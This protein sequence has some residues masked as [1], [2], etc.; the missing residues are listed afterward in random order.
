MKKKHSREYKLLTMCLFCEAAA[1]LLAMLFR[2]VVLN[3]FYWNPDRDYDFYKM[4]FVVVLSFYAVV[5]RLRIKKHPSFREM[6]GWE[7]LAE[8]LKQHIL[9]LIGLTVFL[10]FIHS[11]DKISRT[12]M[13]FL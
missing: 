4:F 1:F 13:G 9:L 6:N 5:F 11:S 12:V 7:H 10:Y 2:Y 8:V 3:S